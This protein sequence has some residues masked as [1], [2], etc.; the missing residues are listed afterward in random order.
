MELAIALYVA[1]VSGVGEPATQLSE[2]NALMEK[3][4]PDMRRLK[5][6]ALW[7]ERIAEERAR[8]RS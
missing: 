5:D 2:A 8:R 7:Q 6:T 1:A 3:L 4:P